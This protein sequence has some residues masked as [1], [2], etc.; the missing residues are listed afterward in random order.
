LVFLPPR[1]VGLLTDVGALSAE[2]PFFDCLAVE[3]SKIQ[4]NC[5]QKNEDVQ[6]TIFNIIIDFIVRTIIKWFISLTF[7]LRGC[8]T[9]FFP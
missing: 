5:L 2:R 3:G 1:A 8:H 4:R 7:L 6:L 9:G